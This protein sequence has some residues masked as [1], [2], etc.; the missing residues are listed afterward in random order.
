MSGR[1][2]LPQQLGAVR[3]TVSA[4]KGLLGGQMSEVSI[5]AIIRVIVNRRKVT[6]N[7]PATL[8]REV[9]YG[10]IAGSRRSCDCLVP[11]G[12]VFGKVVN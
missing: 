1:G 6:V 5:P 12:P 8:F 11:L 10:T 7:L 4:D 3:Q 9:R 2:G